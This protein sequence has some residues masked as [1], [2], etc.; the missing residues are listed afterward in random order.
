MGNDN[1]KKRLKTGLG[2]LLGS[3]SKKVTNNDSKN[4]SDYELKINDIKPNLD[5]PRKFF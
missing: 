5:Q 1:K 3:E 4:L 2:I